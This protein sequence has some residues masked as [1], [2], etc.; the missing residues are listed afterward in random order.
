MGRE[1]KLVFIGKN[2]DGAALAS[3]F[4][5]CLATPEKI[6]KKIEALRFAIGDE[7]ECYMDGWF[8]GIVVAHMYRDEDHMPQGMVVPYQIRLDDGDL[9]W[10]PAD[11]DSVIRAKVQRNGRDTGI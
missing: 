9:I 5:D 11:C 4:N 1:S 3:S 8:S 10:A 2:L 6:A 7:V